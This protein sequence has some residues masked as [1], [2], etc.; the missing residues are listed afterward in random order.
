MKI[1]QALIIPDC[2]IPF[3][4]K[5]AYGLMLDCAKDIE[6]LS[7]I[8]ILGD[9]ADFYNVSFHGKNPDIQETLKDEV[10][11]VKQRLGEI[12]K[13]FP[14]AKIVFIEGNHCFRLNR[15]IQE[16]CPDLYGIFDLYSALDLEKL[17]IELVPYG[18]HQK[19]NVLGVS[20]IAKHEPIGGGVNPSHATVMQAGTS[21][22]MGHTHRL[23]E[24]HTINLEGH[25]ICGINAGWLGD[26]NNA[27]MSYVKNFHRW[28]LG[29]CTVTALEDN[30]WYHQLVKIIVKGKKYRC[31]F[32]GMLYEEDSV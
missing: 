32:N 4:D 2:H 7:E 15:Y 22:V 9:Y 5:T 23:S 8:V 28:N 26:K 25:Q 13:L 18:P 3:E 14:R 31:L 1:R 11:I 19:Y 17:K 30:S 20:L 6:N 27:V 29:F 12:R 16:K 21:V 10:L 24:W